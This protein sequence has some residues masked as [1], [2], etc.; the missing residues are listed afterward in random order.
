MRILIT[1][2]NGFIAK[3]LAQ[4]IID[5]RRSVQDIEIF[6]SFREGKNCEFGHGP[7]HNVNSVIMDL[8][9]RESVLGTI[10]EVD[11][12]KIFHLAG[13][14]SVS[15]SWKAPNLLFRSNLEGTLNL[16]EGV[17]NLSSSSTYVQIAGS[18][19]EY[20]L[21]EECDLPIREDKQLLRP[22]SPY[23]VSKIGS[24]MLGHQ[25][26]H[27]YGLNI[28]RT[29]TFNQTGPGRGEMYADSNFAKQIALI[30]NDLKPPTIDHGNLE[31]VR[32]FTDVRDTVRAYW[33]LSE[34]RW[35]GDVVN[36]CSGTGRKLEETLDILISK[37]S[38]K[39]IALHPDPRRQ[40]PSDVPF[41]FG[42]NQ[43]LK[44]FIDWNPKI[45]YEQSLEDLLEYW[46]SKV[47]SS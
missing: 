38:R 24:D 15:S 28:L 6:L 47:G 2:G 23:A 3:H 30:E 44:S 16:L 10:A 43:K 8:N 42:S 14:S 36:V 26:A 46:R 21:V 1:G 39:D 25:Y 7:N 11:P 33:K 17:R 19:E 18:S 34:L 31:A 45:P 37:S 9:D 13:A 27:S 20:G 4:H 35:R 29:R 40:R 22:L 5:L 32:D 41:S 12:D